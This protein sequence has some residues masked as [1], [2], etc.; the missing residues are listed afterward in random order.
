MEI[1]AADDENK[2]KNVNPDYSAS[3]IETLIMIDR[4]I[5]FMTP[6]CTQ[7]VYEG[8][9]DDFYGISANLLKV[10]G[11]ILGAPKGKPVLIE[12]SGFNNSLYASIRDS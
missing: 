3:E 5:D 7:L 12:L 6:L 8:L 4:N 9:V 10:D 1:L 11:E 2:S